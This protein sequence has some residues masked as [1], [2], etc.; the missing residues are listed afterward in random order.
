[1]AKKTAKQLDSMSFEDKL[2]ETAELL[3]GAVSPSEYKNIALGLMFLKFI[4][5][6]FEERKNQLEK[7]SRN[8][9]SDNYCKTDKQ[10]QYLLNLKDQYISKGAFF[11]KE[12]DNWSDLKKIAASEKNLGIKIDKMLLEIE[13]DNSTLESVLPKIFA[14]APIPNQNLQQLIEL[15]DT[16][17]TD[18]DA[19]HDSFGRIYEYFM[20]MFSK[21]LGE[22]GGEFF[23]PRSIVKLLVEILEPYSGIIYDPTCGS[24]GMFVQSYKFLQA[25]KNE[26]QNGKKGLSVYGVEKRNEIWRICKMNLAIRGIDSK[27]IIRA[28]SLLENPFPKLLANRILANPPF[29]QREW[30]YE[31]LKEDK[32]FAQFGVPTPSKPGGNYAFME[33]ML[34]HLDKKE[35]RMGLVLANGSMSAGGTEGKIRQKIVESDYV[36]CMI[37][38]PTNLFFTVTIPACLWFFT[39]NKDDG[40]T[41]K[42]TGKTLFI[43]T[44]KIFTKVDRNLNEFSDEQIEKMTGTYRSYIG[45]KGYPKY[46]D[47]SG[48]CK[49][50][51]KEEIAK[52]N[53]VLTPGRYVGAEE[54]EDDDEPFEDKMNKLVSEYT[55]L[56]E[57]SKT[58]DKEIRKNLKEL[59]F[60]I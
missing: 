54:I 47:I 17:P 53:F 22:K 46:K 10:R 52:N 1:M 48:Y 11:L 5:D 28:D 58:L 36:D 51:T 26:I 21:K 29:N 43:D 60:A 30:G 15:F 23:T 37:A 44:R 33:H 3:I 49:I 24:G 19:E 12:G 56:S 27:N 50:A 35:G 57:E 9:K 34:Y 16:I 55:K 14:S 4:S 31:Q 25:H 20:K 2:W 41:K 40:K 13:K 18:S 59:G 42:R 8:P 6:R 45:E 39:K 7:E 32:Q 38:L